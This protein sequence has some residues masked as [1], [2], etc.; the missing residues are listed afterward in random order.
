MCKRQKHKYM[1][2]VTVQT[3]SQQGIFNLTKAEYLIAAE[4]YVG[5]GSIYPDK[6]TINDVLKDLQENDVN[7]IQVVDYWTKPRKQAKSST[8][9]G[10]SAYGH[11]HRKWNTNF[12]DFKHSGQLK[13]F[14]VYNR[15][16]QNQEYCVI[17]LKIAHMFPFPNFDSCKVDK[18]YI[19]IMFEFDE[20]HFICYLLCALVEPGSVTII[21]QEKFL[22]S[23]PSFLLVILCPE[24]SR[25][26]RS[27]LR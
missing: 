19:E 10:I 8:E 3:I 11:W 5:Y 13:E 7:V 23:T 15:L 27:F 12:C 2:L 9:G 24:F 1:L 20:S 6:E 4:D 16:Y 22:L 17:N 25:Y 21:V 26:L 14:L 18:I